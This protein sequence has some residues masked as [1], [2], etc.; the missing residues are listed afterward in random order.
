[1]LRQLELLGIEDVLPA[2]YAAEASELMQRIVRTVFDE[3]IRRCKTG[4]VRAAVGMIGF[5]Y[6]GGSGPPPSASRPSPGRST[7]SSA[8]TGRSVR[9]SA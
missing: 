2:A 9:P 6:R 3:R 8:T 5:L 4:D 7:R 1:M